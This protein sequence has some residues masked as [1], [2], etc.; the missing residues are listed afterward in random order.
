MIKIHVVINPINT[1]PRV[2]LA[3]ESRVKLGSV[4]H[5]WEGLPALKPHKPLPVFA[6]TSKSK[7]ARLL[8]VSTQELALGI[9]LSV[10]LICCSHGALSLAH[11]SINLAQLWQSLP[12]YH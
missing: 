4:L 9:M 2:L 6:G 8:S 12:A 11:N 10:C 7:A 1:V 3:A 5:I